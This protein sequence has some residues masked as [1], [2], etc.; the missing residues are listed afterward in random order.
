[1]KNNAQTAVRLKNET[2][3]KTSSRKYR[4]IE[5]FNAADFENSLRKERKEDNQ[6]SRSSSHA[7]AKEY[8]LKRKEKI[9]V[10]PKRKISPLKDQRSNHLNNFSLE[11]PPK[12]RY[13]SFGILHQKRGIKRPREYKLI[14]SSVRET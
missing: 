8:D 12:H 14:E 4:D 5:D 3:T 10:F 11:K 9:P 13:L 2:N 6:G 7:R 1:M